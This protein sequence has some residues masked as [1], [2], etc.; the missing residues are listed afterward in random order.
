M[1]SACAASSIWT[2]ALHLFNVM[3]SKRLHPG[4]ITRNAAFCLRNSEKLWKLKV[5]PSCLWREHWFNVLQVF[6]CLNQIYIH[7]SWM[8]S[9]QRKVPFHWNLYTSK[10]FAEETNTRFLP[11]AFLGHHSLRESTSMANCIGVVACRWILG[12]AQGILVGKGI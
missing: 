2:M 3:P 10:R 9:P 1:L 11:P 6:E 8:I 5:V 4:Q 12:F 7:A